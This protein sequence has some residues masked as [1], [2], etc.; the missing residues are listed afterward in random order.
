MT[1]TKSLSRLKILVTRPTHQAVNLCNAIR[2]LGGVPILFP[3]LEIESLEDKADLVAATSQLEKYDLVI[4]TS[5]NAVLNVMPYWSVSPVSDLVV[6]AIGPA[7]MQ[8]LAQYKIR[9]DVLPVNSY[10]S[11]GLLN[12]PQLLHSEGKKVMIFS[13]V[14]GRILLA[15]ALKQR[16]AEVTQVAVYRRILPQQNSDIW[17]KIWHSGDV[18]IIISTSNESLRN[19]LNLAGTAS[20]HWLLGLPLLVISQR[21]A[22]FA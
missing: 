19:L 11:E 2:A 20:R 4:F 16:G 10:N 6:A 9:A 3:T 8:I 7:T 14:G 13:G 5:A 12:H 22:S 17:T 21:M 1:N 18:D 15:D